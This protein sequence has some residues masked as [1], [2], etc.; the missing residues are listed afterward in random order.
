V[1]TESDAI[2]EYICTKYKRLDLIGENAESR[3]IYSW[4]KGVV[5]DV[6]F[7]VGLLAYD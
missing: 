5:W 2:A 7:E 1:L 6:R 3:I 4:I